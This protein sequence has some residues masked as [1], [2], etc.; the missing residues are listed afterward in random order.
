MSSYFNLSFCE[1]CT[2]A[3]INTTS[4]RSCL[5]SDPLRRTWFLQV[6]G[7][8]APERQGAERGFSFHFYFLFL[9]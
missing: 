8:A 5:V 3:L 1:S 9:A 4:S 6:S 7:W 2:G